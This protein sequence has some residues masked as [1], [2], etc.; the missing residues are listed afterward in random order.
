MSRQPLDVVVVGGG[1]AGLSAALVLGRMRRRVLLLD[2]D[3]PANVVSQGV[4]GFLSRDGTPPAEV[5][6]IGREQLAPYE[7]VECRAAA[8]RSARR[9]A[10]DRFAV[11]LDDGV[12]VEAR[13]LLLAHGTRY[14][15]PDL[16]GVAE[17]WGRHVFHC[18]YC[19]GWEVRDRPIAVYGRGPRAV[20]QA[21]MLSSLSDDVVLLCD[22]APELTDEERERL[23]RASVSLHDGVVDRVEQQGAALRVVFADGAGLARHALFVQPALSPASDLAPSLGAALTDAGT[24]EADETGRTAVPGLYAAGDAGAAVQSVAVATGTGARAAYAINAELVLEDSA[25]APPAGSAGSLS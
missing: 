6:R 1:P 17:L 5:R 14:G 12:V 4:H 7:S 25:P 3:S 23:A 21:L 18:P 24:V 9:L 11:G 19:H 2:T 8:A 20:H 15:L 16:D 10:D 13:R 22:G